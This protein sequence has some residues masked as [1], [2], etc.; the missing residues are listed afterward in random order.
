GLTQNGDRDETLDFGFVKPSVSVGDYVW[1]DVNKDGKQDDT[2]KP[3][4]GVTLTLTG[5]NG[6]PV[7]DINGQ[8][9]QPTQTD[10]QGHYSFEKLP[11]LAA[12]QKYK[13]TVT[14]PE[15]YIPTKPGVG[16]RDKDSS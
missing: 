9:V 8:K 14:A 2:D 6:Q 13:V 1:F 11:V 3:I 16:A 15:G 4:S 5:P 10:D 7:T 12:G